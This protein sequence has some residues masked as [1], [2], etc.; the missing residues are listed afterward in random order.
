MDDDDYGAPT[1]QNNKAAIGQNAGLY[2]ELGQLNPKRAKAEQKR[3]KK[4]RAAAAAGG[5][6]AEGDESDFDFDEANEADGLQEG[7]SEVGC[8]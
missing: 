2:N 4:E 3:L 7:S 8:I 6:A 5:G 1:R